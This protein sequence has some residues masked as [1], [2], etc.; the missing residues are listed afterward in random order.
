MLNSSRIGLGVPPD[1]NPAEFFVKLVSPVEIG[2]VSHAERI[3]KLCS[4]NDRKLMDV[5]R[6]SDKPKLSATDIE[7]VEPLFWATQIFVLL[8]R[9]FVIGR[10]DL[11]ETF[12]NSSSCIMIALGIG[13]V[14]S[15]EAKNSQAAIADAQGMFFNTIAQIYFYTYKSIVAVFTP[16]LPVVR[17]ETGENLY[18]ISSYYIMKFLSLVSQ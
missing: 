13:I 8:K 15:G 18:S 2:G 3:E 5:V 6:A 9:A 4:V 16:E 1:Y 17:K 14:F 12:M 10:R 11:G 7:R